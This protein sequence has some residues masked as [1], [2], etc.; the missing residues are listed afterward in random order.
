MQ[1]SPTLNHALKRF[2]LAMI[3]F[4]ASGY[5]G[6]ITPFDRHSLGAAALRPSPRAP[7][8]AA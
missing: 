4:L 5:F 1:S 3:I 7:T 8:G 2:S 6:W